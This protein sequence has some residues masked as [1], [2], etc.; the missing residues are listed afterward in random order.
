LTIF[1]PSNLIRGVI[2]GGKVGLGARMNRLSLKSNLL[3]VIVFGPG[4]GESIVLH[5]PG[6]PS[7]IWCVID[8]CRIA[9]ANP[10]CKLLDDY[11][12]RISLLAISH[13]HDDH[14]T[15]FDDLFQRLEAN[16]YVGA[17]WPRLPEETWTESLDARRH[18]LKGSSEAA[19]AAIMGHW[20]SGTVQPW[21]MSRGQARQLSC[22]D[23]RVLNPIS[24]AYA[25]CF[26]RNTNL[27][28]TAL[29]IEW[30]D[31]RILL[32]GD[33]EKSDWQ[34][35]QSSG[36]CVAHQACKV[37]HH[38]S[39]SAFHSSWMAGSRTRCWCITPWHGKRLPWGN[40]A[41]VKSLVAGGNPVYMTSSEGLSPNLPSRTIT[42][43]GGGTTPLPTAVVPGVSLTPHSLPADALSK[44]VALGYD[45]CGNLAD[46]QFG[47]GS[48]SII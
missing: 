3:Y 10:A 11:D 48:A 29:L 25:H 2:F 12:A 18:L 24:P 20:L 1:Q 43:H 4:T 46:T 7:P 6:D 30:E 33:V 27:L 39:D 13:P 41:G 45:G 9:K 34:G 36:F 22:C 38:G 37:P 32:G 21:E 23:I 5:I 42:V 26:P 16:A 31:C 47:D 35:I 14:A 8:S 15:G 19:V 44:F 28:S 40:G 17:A